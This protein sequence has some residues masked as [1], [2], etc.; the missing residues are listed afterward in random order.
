MRSAWKSFWNLYR[1]ELR[2]NYKSFLIWFI[3][4]AVLLFL[5]MALV[6]SFQSSDY[7]ELV[8]AKIN[9]IPKGLGYAFGL[10]SS[11]TGVNFQ[12]VIFY[13]GY[14][15]Q[16][17]AVAIIIYA[18]N[19]GSGIL[20]KENVDKHIDY[21]ASKPIKKSTIVIAKYKVLLTYILLFSVALFV[22][23]CISILIF[24]SKHEPFFAEITRLFVKLFFEY[25][26]F[27]TLAFFVSAI[28]KRTVKSN[29]VVV[30]IFFVTY[31][32]GIAAQLLD[33]LEKLRYLSPYFMFQANVAGYSFSTTDYWYMFTLFVLSLLLFGVALWRYTSKDLSL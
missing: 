18:I 19:L 26:I 10:N 5:F 15:T 6:P 33:K 16:F 13:F 23:G 20:S 29:L 2:Q 1:F 21:L 17:F 25:L 22:V 8:N 24:N 4:I 11:V 32:A 12:D 7:L 3:S 30:G 9:A 28:S 14:M 27:G 31:L